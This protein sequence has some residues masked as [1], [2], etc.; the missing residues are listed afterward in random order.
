LIDG[1]QTIIDAVH[2]N[3]AKGRILKSDLTTE[4]CFVVKHENAFA[5]GA[6]LR[7]AMDALNEKLF[8]DMPVEDR[9]AEFVKQFR[10]NTEYP[11][12]DFFSW[13][14][15]LTGSCEQGRRVFAQ[16]HGI[17]VE[18]DKM[19]VARFVDLTQNAYGGEVIRQLKS[20]YQL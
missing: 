18:H 13:H 4:P 20:E 14:N 9:I 1:V 16:E 15:K 8:E 10:P 17:D 11:A 2:G 3:T 7:E 19:T 5:H 12:K 6:T